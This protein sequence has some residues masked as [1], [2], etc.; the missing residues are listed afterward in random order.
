MSPLYDAAPFPSMIMETVTV[1]EGAQE[2]RP[3]YM[4]VDAVLP[5]DQIVEYLN[6]VMKGCPCL[7][8]E[9]QAVIR[10]KLGIVCTPVTHTRNVL[11]RTLALAAEDAFAGTTVTREA[12][13]AAAA[14]AHNRIIAIHPMYDGNGRLA[15]ALA[16]WVLWMNGLTPIMRHC[17]AYLEASIRDGQD[18]PDVRDPSAPPN[19]CIQAMAAWISRTEREAREG[20]LC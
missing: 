12:A 17:R 20:R 19:V 11:A 4:D 14:T 2:P 9:L 3:I 6:Y 1:S 10:S 18:A 7:S 16:N 5:Q 8:P 15:R 13:I